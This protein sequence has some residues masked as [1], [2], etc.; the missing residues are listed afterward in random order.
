MPLIDMMPLLRRC[1]A[2]LPDAITIISDAAYAVT[3]HA[4]ELPIRRCLRS[5]F[6]A[7]IDYF[8]LLRCRCRL[9]RGEAIF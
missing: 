7:A 6:A 4:R 1:R 2:I 3:R 5:L 8:R 9:I